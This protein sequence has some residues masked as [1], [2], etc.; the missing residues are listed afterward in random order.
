MMLNRLDIER[1]PNCGVNRPDVSAVNSGTTKDFQNENEQFWKI[2]SCRRCGGIILALSQEENG[3]IVRMYPELDVINDK[4]PERAR[5]YL[6]QALDSISAPAA[7]IIVA[8]SSV[9]SMLKA[10]GYKTGS[11]DSRIK[12]AAEDHLLTDEMKRWAEQVKVDA[13]YQR[14]ADDSEPLPDQRDAELVIEFAQALGEFLFVL[15]DRVTRGV[16]NSSDTTRPEEES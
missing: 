13:N 12:K 10:K 16:Q 9:D 14:H 1:C 2:Y 6:K 7:S 5:A 11:L 4:I 3:A 15:P 8:A